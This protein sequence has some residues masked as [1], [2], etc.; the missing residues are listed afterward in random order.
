MKAAQIERYSKEIK[1]KINDIPIP[2]IKEDEVLVRVKAAAVNPVDILNLK[3]SVRLIQDYKMPLTLGIECSGEVEK[4][5][6]KVKRFNLGDKVYSRIP[7]KTLG[8]F[9]EFVSIK[10]S[11]LAHMAHGLYYDTAA[12]IPLTGLTAYEAITEEMKAKPGE[13]L[14]I[15]GGSGSFGQM[16]VPILSV[17]VSGNKWA[18]EAITA[19]GAERY[20]VYTEEN[21]EEVLPP[22]DYVIDTLGE[23]EFEKELSILR[24]GGRCLVA[25]K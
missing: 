24:K 21:Y 18:K 8:A 13:S 25:E 15:P 12:A 22:L 2:S 5:G 20:I 3:G 17:V 6:S 14:F 11:A 10:E 23:R 16:A 9:A 7:I 1:V 19:L 4:I